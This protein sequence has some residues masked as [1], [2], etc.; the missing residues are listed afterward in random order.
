M[1]GSPTMISRRPLRLFFA[2]FGALLALVAI[3]WSAYWTW[4]TAVEIDRQPPRSDFKEQL[5]HRKTSALQDILE[6]MIR[7][8]M[9]LVETA[10]DRME[11]YGSTIKWYLS[12]VEYREHGE[13]FRDATDALRAAARAG[14]LDSAKEATLRLERSCL[15]CHIQ[16]NQPA[17]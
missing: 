14:D 3:V 5:M 15:D 6:G 12:A 17:R 7:G 8:D 2:V 11:N 9:R 4:K 1:L 16:I 13:S 10:A